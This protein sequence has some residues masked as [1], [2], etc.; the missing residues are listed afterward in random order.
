MRLS[1]RDTLS[2]IFQLQILWFE[3]P[4]CEQVANNLSTD[5]DNVVSNSF[6]VA[7][8]VSRETA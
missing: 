2:N 1:I 7:N 6:S 4:D 3:T 8:K 5:A